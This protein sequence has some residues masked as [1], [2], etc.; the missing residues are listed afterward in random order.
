MEAELDCAEVKRHVRAALGTDLEVGASTKQTQ[1]QRYMQ[2]TKTTGKEPPCPTSRP[3]GFAG[4]STSSSGDSPALLGVG[5]LAAAFAFARR[6]R[7]A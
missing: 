6:R 7:S 2:A 3:C 5:A 4:C 1:V